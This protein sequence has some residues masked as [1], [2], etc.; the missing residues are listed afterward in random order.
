M[1]WQTVLVLALAVPVVLLTPA[2]VWFLNITGILEVMKEAVARDRRRA[3]AKRYA[4]A[5]K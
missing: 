1:Q 4:L 5:I 3:K 2:L